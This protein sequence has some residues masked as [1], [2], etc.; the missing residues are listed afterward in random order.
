MH[1]PSLSKIIFFSLSF[2]LNQH[3]DCW[4]LR[5]NTR[6]LHVWLSNILG[7]DM[8]HHIYSLVSSTTSQ[9]VCTLFTFLSVVFAEMTFYPFSK[10]YLLIFI[11]GCMKLP[12]SSGWGL[13][14]YCRLVH[15]L[16]AFSKEKRW[17]SK[18]NHFKSAFFLKQVN[19]KNEF[20]T[21]KTT[22]IYSTY[23]HN[24]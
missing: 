14:R 13:W 17:N 10:G 18:L 23:K 5:E 6:R 11:F 9:F 19:L 2:R 20:P 7:F 12:F 8:S 22:R 1:R 16:D 24:F 4:T 21:C 3:N 15:I